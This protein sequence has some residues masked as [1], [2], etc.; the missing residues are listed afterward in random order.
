VLK[1]KIE[2]HGLGHP[3]AINPRRENAAGIAGSFSS[4]IEALGVHTLQAGV[5]RQANGR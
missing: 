4:G 2:R 1:T 3:D 5:A